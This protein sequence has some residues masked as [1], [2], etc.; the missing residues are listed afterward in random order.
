MCISAITFCITI[1]FNTLFDKSNPNEIS[2]T[3][4]RFQDY[5]LITSKRVAETNPYWQGL[6]ASEKFKPDGYAKGY[7]RYAQDV[8]IPSFIA[9]YTKKDIY[10]V[11]LLNQNNNNI[12]SNPFSGIIPKP[13][14]RLTYTGLTKIPSLAKNFNTISFLV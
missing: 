2:E 13:N 1:A 14:W 9:A 4:K 10:S 3:F 7:S 5:R 8:L 12:R 6:P 11:S